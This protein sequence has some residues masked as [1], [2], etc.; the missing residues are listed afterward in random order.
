MAALR[1][2][3]EATF[4]LRWFIQG[5]CISVLYF[6]L[7][8]YPSTSPFIET[9]S[10][11][12]LESIVVY[13]LINFLYCW[14]FYK[15]YFTRQVAFQGC[16]LGVLSGTG[17]IIGFTSNTFHPFGWYLVILSFFHF[18]EFF[19]TCI[20]NYESLSLDSYLLNHSIAYHVAALASWLEFFIELYFFPGLKSLWYISLLGI[21]LCVGG[22]FLRKGAMLTAGRSFN[23]YIQTTKADDHDLVT[24]GVYS[25]SRHPSYVGWFY[26]S[27]G[28]QLILCNPLCCLAYSITSWRFFNERVEDEEITLVAFFGQSYVDY[29][30]KVGTKLPFIHGYRL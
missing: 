11:R 15:T 2:P 28:T 25:W 16:L 5:N 21:A 26:W 1:V 4:S 22:E 14:I 3:P 6:L 27:I 9:F 30:K 20:Y 18:S 24:H 8:S 13:A 23:H 29:Q 12:Y 7:R 10:Q 17:L 19:S